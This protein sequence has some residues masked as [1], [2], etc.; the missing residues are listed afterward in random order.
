MKNIDYFDYIDACVIGRTSDNYDDYIDDCLLYEYYC[1]GEY[2][3]A[4]DF[5][6]LISNIIFDFSVAKNSKL[7]FDFSEFVD[8]YSA[9][10]MRIVEKMIDK[11]SE[12][13][14][15]LEQDINSYRC[16]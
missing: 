8:E 10:E 6:Q 16:P 14:R 1:N 3:H 9:Q 4:H 15:I 11:L 7:E 2:R 12:D 5:R 13:K